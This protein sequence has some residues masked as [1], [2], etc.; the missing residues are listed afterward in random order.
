M[1]KLIH[2]FDPIVDGGCRILVLGTMPGEESLRKQQYY[3]HP[4]NAFWPIMAALC[5]QELPDAYQHR[6]AMLLETRIALWDVC[7]RARRQPRQ[8][9]QQRSTEPHR[10]TATAIPADPHN[11]F[12][13]AV[14][15]AAFQT[16]FSECRSGNHTDH[17]AVDQSGTR[18]S[19][20][21]ETTGLAGRKRF[22]EISRTQNRLKTAAGFKNP[23]AV[24]NSEQKKPETLSGRKISREGFSSTLRETDR[25]P[26][27]YRR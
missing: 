8:Q 3:G 1:G 16:L 27:L 14:C 17:P 23:A 9:H 4:R 20:G 15:R 18:R 25:P 21:E 22:F 10:G 11:R 5:G 13:R 26:F 12:Q 2:S 7:R 19:V 6:K 24:L